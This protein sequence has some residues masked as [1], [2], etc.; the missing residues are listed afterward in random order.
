MLARSAL[1]PWH[2]CI[3]NLKL[4][5]RE[6]HRNPNIAVTAIGTSTLRQR[7][8]LRTPTRFHDTNPSGMFVL[9]LHSNKTPCTLSHPMSHFTMWQNPTTS[10]SWDGPTSAKL[11]FQL[12]ATVTLRLPRSTLRATLPQRPRPR[13]LSTRT[14]LITSILIAPEST[15]TALSPWGCSHHNRTPA[16]APRWVPTGY[17]MAN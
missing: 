17:R 11:D 5:T 15:Y 3:V 13:N 2:I 7:D 8:F 4:W 12:A 9:V 14:I 10:S 1:A 6:R 16:A